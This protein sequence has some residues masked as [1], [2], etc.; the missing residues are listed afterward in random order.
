MANQADNPRNSHH[1][2]GGRH[3]V[4]LPTTGRLGLSNFTVHPSPPPIPFLAIHHPGN[5]NYSLQ[6]PH[7]GDSDPRKGTPYI[8]ALIS[9]AQLA[10]PQVLSLGAVQV[11]THGF[12]EEAVEEVK[13]SACPADKVCVID[14]WNLYA[15]ETA[16]HDEADTGDSSKAPVLGRLAYSGF[17]GHWEAVKD[18]PNSEGWH[19]YWR[20]P[21]DWRD[22]G[23]EL[24]SPIEIEIVP[25]ALLGQADR[26]SHQ[27]ENGIWWTNICYNDKFL[28]GC[29]TWL[30]GN[31]VC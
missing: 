10:N 18:A 15:E 17:E 27:D 25:A 23:V 8:A 24:G 13:V 5:S 3:I 16:I 31:R 20:A 11:R 30:C 19:V 26:A 2:L 7:P 28:Y 22:D 21:G 12:A 9:K 14:A 6:L 1:P 29:P 4:Q